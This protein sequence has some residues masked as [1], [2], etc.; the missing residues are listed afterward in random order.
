MNPFK[1]KLKVLIK[2]NQNQIIYI[3]SRE[4]LLTVER[5]VRYLTASSLSLY[6]IQVIQKDLIGM[7]LEAEKEGISLLDKL[8]TNSREFCDDVINTGG[9]KAV[10]EHIIDMTVNVLQFSALWMSL[11]FFIFLSAPGT[12]GIAWEDLMVIFFY[13]TCGRFFLPIFVTN[14]QCLPAHLCV[15]CHS[16]CQWL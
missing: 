14:L 9:N 16:P 15:I 12:F 3:E 11:K 2:E 4:N 10:N 7:A 8:G 1:N 5:M 13:Y 6:Q